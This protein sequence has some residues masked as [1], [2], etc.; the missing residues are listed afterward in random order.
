MAAQPGTHPLHHRAHHVLER[1]RLQRGDQR[2]RPEP[3][4]IHEVRHQ[5]VEPLALLEDRPKELVALV[6]R[7]GNAFLEEA[8]GAGSDRREWRPEVV[9]DRGEEGGPDAAGLRLD[10]RLGRG[11]GEAQPLDGQGEL[12]GERRQD[13][14]LRPTAVR[15]ARDV[16][17]ADRVVAR[18]QPDGPHVRRVDRARRHLVLRPPLGVR[19]H[20]PAPVQVV[21]RAQRFGEVL[22]HRPERRPRQEP[23]GHVVQ[24]AD[25]VLAELRPG[26]LLEG[27]GERRA[28]GRRDH[29]E[30]G[31]RDEVLGLRHRERVAG[32]REVVVEAGEGQR[33]GQQRRPQ[34]PHRR[35]R[36]HRQQ[37][38]KGRDRRP[39]S[40]REGRQDRHD[41]RTRHGHGEAG[42]RLAA[43]GPRQQAL[44][45]FRAH[46]VL[47]SGSWSPRCA[48]V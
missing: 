47:I 20:H 31:Q 15:G 35:G 44:E 9:R 30:D 17:V 43:L 24:G 38:Q 25:L 2:A 16:D 26:P 37:I 23:R 21:E 40:S 19:D 42:Q 8:R 27:G 11:L 4:E 13:L 48:L 10:P 36:H 7:E 28:H 32:R 1:D 3:R 5:A 6:L 46:V 22:E 29:E 39:L 33:R 45:R 41:Q 12:S 14:R 18:D 34:P